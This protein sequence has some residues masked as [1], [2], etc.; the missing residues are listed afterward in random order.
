MCRQLITLALTL[1]GLLG[2]AGPALAADEPR[3]GDPAHQYA[4][5][6]YCPR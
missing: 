3:P 4:N 5:P 2:V 6:H 1:A